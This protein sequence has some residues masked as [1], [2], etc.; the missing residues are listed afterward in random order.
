MKK[1]VLAT[2]LIG[3]TSCGGLDTPRDVALEVVAV[4]LPTTLAPGS[5]LSV[6]VKYVENCTLLNEKL[7]LVE[8][9]SSALKLA[10]VGT[11]K[12]PGGPCPAVYREQTLTYVDSGT[13]GRTTPFEVIVNGK[14]WGTIEVR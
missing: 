8:R 7:L 12:T 6:T 5:D 2:L 11:P 13:V 3:L 4:T 10:A 14:S 9:R 1:L